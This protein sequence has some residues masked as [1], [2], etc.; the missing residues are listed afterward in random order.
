MMTYSNVMLLVCKW[1]CSRHVFFVSIWK[2]VLIRF[3][4]YVESLMYYGQDLSVY[5]ERVKY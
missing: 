4:K 1:S 3:L 2:I 5:L